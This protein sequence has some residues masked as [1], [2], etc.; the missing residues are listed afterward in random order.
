MRIYHHAAVGT[1]LFV[2]KMISGQFSRSHEY[3][4][5][6]PSYDALC[7]DRLSTGAPPC[8]ALSCCHVAP[9][10]RAALF[11]FP[12]GLTAV[13]SAETPEPRLNR[14]YVRFRVVAGLIG[15]I[16]E[17]SRFAWI[18]GFPEPCKCGNDLLDRGPSLS[19]VHFSSTSVFS[20]ISRR[21]KGHF[22][23]SLRR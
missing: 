15:N 6:R 14:S 4:L 10:H 13:F 11:F 23:G 2:V 8:G 12:P 16:E 7:P 9:P 19:V 22:A 18:G 3:S 1:W 17:S 5:T 21:Q 20:R